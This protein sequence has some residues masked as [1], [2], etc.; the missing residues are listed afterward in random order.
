MNEA[1]RRFQ[2]WLAAGADGEPPRDLAVHASVCADCQRS[3]AALDRLAAIDP[4][5][6]AMPA[7]RETVPEARGGAVRM[8]RLVG[9]AAGVLFSAVILGIGAS[10]LISL[11]RSGQVGQ[12]T[13]TPGQGQFFTTTPEP[14]SG[15]SIASPGESFPPPATPT[16][17]PIPTPEPT[18]PPKPGSPERRAALR[19]S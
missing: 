12:A 6:A 15:E 1:H 9:A 18:P 5:R 7:A 13:P 3:I 11:S 17:T 14:S 16:P 2:E 10:Q 19:P 8:G 4:S